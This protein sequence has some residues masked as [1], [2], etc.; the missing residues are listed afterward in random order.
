MSCC[1]A[2]KK[3]WS[4]DNMDFDAS[5]STIGI[6]PWTS[7]FMYN[8][9]HFRLRSFP[10]FV[11]YRLLM[12]LFFIGIVTSSLYKNWSDG[13]W[14][15]YLTHWTL[16][17]QVLY[18]C[19]SLWTCWYPVKWK[20][21]A[22]IPFVYRLFW[23]LRVILLGATLLVAILYWTLVF[24]YSTSPRILSIL[25]HGTGFI[26]MLI[27]GYIQP[28]PV[29]LLQV[30]YCM[31]YAFLY[32]LWSIVHYVTGIGNEDGERYIYKSLDWGHPTTSTTL[33]FIIVLVLIPVLY[34][35]FWYLYLKSYHRV[36]IYQSII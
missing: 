25:T 17:L 12:C 6:L 22:G 1:K 24:D 28:L 18:F 20:N 23:A 14:C 29:L 11:C 19:I 4:V 31:L 9:K 26:C 34:H 21:Q 30:T 35:I 2:Y 5:T 33:A 15:I 8:D 27:D 10:V 3:E 13:Y 36:P 32:C 16:V 7:M